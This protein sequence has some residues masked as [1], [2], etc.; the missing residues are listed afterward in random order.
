MINIQ[1]DL[2]RLNSLLRIVETAHNRVLELLSRYNSIHD[3]G[4]NDQDLHDTLQSKVAFC[5]T[6]SSVISLDTV[7]SVLDVLQQHCTVYVVLESIEEYALIIEG[8]IIINNVP[9]V[10]I[11][12]KY[13]PTTRLSDD[14]IDT[15]KHKLQKLH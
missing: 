6:Q 3:S 14:A 15:I 4:D 11:D 13:T 5:C 9:L 2:L 12:N 1:Q 7:N 8:S 10:L